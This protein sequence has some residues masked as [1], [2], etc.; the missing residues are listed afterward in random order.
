MSGK[1]ICDYIK[2]IAEGAQT[3]CDRLQASLT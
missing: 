3:A 1:N 2:A